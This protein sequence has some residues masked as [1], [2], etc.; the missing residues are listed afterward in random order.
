MQSIVRPGRWIVAV[1]VLLVPLGAVTSASAATTSKPY[2]LTIARGTPAYETNTGGLANNEV[3]S[4]ETVGITAMFTNETKTQQLGSANLFWPSGFNVVHASVAPPATVS[5][6]SSCTLGG[7]PAGPCVQA[8]NLALAPGGSATVTMSVATPPG[9]P[10]NNAWQAEVKQAN[11]FSGTPGNDF[12]LDS[13]TSQPFTFL[14]GASSVAFVNQ[15]HNE[16]LGN[17]IDGATDWFT[18]GA[19]AASPLTVAVLAADGTV[20]SGFTA[21]VTAAI[22]VNPGSGTLS[23]TNPQTPSSGIAA[24]NDLQISAPA[25]GYELSASSGALST[26]TST[27]FD[28]AGTAAACS[29]PGNFCQTDQTGNGGDAS[30]AATVVSGSGL[31]LESANANS[32]AELTCSGSTS[33]D[34]NTYTF[35]TTGNLVASKVATITT[36]GVR[37]SGSVTKF[38]HAQQICFG[39]AVDFITASGTLAPAGTLPDGSSG[40]VGVLPNCTGTSTGPCHDQNSDSATLVGSTYTV[41]LVADI[42][43]AYA[44][45]PW[46]H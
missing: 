39:G 37:I 43:A 46:M 36:L 6:S 23:G 3:A 44:G 11:D 29:G 20:V 28:V 38:L 15:P 19:T 41:R 45:D 21:P 42:P 8:R 5:V 14:D 33:I 24:F 30:L 35:L 31:L 27:A 40:F 34:P 13:G 9:Q 2:S 26:T 7:S 10:G 25:N 1:A 12:F 22:A 17:A 4:G 16:I 18:A 32:G